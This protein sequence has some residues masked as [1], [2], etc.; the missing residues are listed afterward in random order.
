MSGAVYNSVYVCAYEMLIVNQQIVVTV[1][2]TTILLAEACCYVAYIVVAIVF[3]NDFQPQRAVIASEVKPVRI[4][5]APLFECFPELLHCIG[6]ISLNRFKRYY[7]SVNPC[8]CGKV[9]FVAALCRV[10][11]KAFAYKCRGKVAREA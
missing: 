8:A 7:L 11:F 9:V 10:G 4:I 3:F 6:G 2:T 1:D 5:V